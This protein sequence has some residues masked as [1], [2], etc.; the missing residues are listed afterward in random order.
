[1][2]CGHSIIIKYNQYITINFIET[3]HLNDYGGMLEGIELN[4]GRK[5]GYGS[6]LFL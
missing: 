2:F 1:M 5:T 6:H 3:D 4:F